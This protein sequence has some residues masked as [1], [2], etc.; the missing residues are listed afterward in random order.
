MHHIMLLYVKKFRGNY[1]FRIL[2][3]IESLKHLLKLEIFFLDQFNASLVNKVLVS[4]KRILN[5]KLLNGC[6]ST[7]FY[8]LY[9]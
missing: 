4:L 8:K 2:W 3:R 5:S 6:S 7:E 1:F 9:H